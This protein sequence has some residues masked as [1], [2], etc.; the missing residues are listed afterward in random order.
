[1]IKYFLIVALAGLT[2]GANAQTLKMG[3]PAPPI[4]FG[5]WVKGKPFQE[6]E[7]GKIYV[8][9]FW[10][11]WCG[12]CKRAIPH[13]TR[14][15]K[16]Y[17]QEVVFTGV[18]VWELDTKL[19]APFV[20]RMGAEMDYNVVI[21]NQDADTARAGYMTQHWLTPMG[22]RSI[23]ATVV[24]GKT[25]LIEWHGHPNQLESVLNQLVKGRWDPG[26][27]SKQLVAKDSLQNM[28][29]RLGANPDWLAIHREIAGKYPEISAD[30]S[31]LVLKMMHLGRNY[32][33][34]EAVAIDYLRQYGKSL[35]IHELNPIG[36]NFFVNCTDQSKI[37]EVAGLFE[38]KIASGSDKSMA[39][40]IDTYA[41]L[42]YKSAEKDKALK[43][44]FEAYLMI[45]EDEIRY[46]VDHGKILVGVRKADFLITAY[47]MEKGMPIWETKRLDS[48]K[49]DLKA[50]NK[51]WKKLRDRMDD[52]FSAKKAD[53]LL[54]FTKM[55]Y[56]LINKQT[57]NYATCLVEYIDKNYAF[58][59]AAEHNKYAWE[60]F[61]ISNNAD[62]LKTALGWM[63]DIVHDAN[64]PYYTYNLDTYANLQYKLGRKSDALRWQQKAVDAAPES[65][66]A[67]YTATLNKMKNGEKTWQ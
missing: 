22:Y 26:Q 52:H 14:L 57:E 15:A 50:D 55:R 16:H 61:T 27:F 37:K 9:E 65:E 28:A 18:S 23:P 29:G 20:Q 31:V 3:Q 47:K 42:L 43:H 13:L 53:S 40:M 41:C 2:L 51:H 60:I 46:D 33:E 21:D 36:W 11:T 8:L 10:A 63:T 59:N 17:E 12:P 25:G 45:D 64:D 48:V 35:T 19:V 24:V 44:Q 67:N 54:A 7:P 58:K 5:T 1:M 49:T 34:Y 66:K 30:S 39:D 4:Q 56:Y 32:H 38:R 6:F 62:E